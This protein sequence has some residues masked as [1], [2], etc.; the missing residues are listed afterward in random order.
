MFDRGQ[1][2]AECLWLIYFLED[3][4]KTAGGYVHFLLGNH[5]IMNLNND[6][7]YMKDKYRNNSRLLGVDYISLYGENSELGRWLRTKNIMERIGDMLFVHG[8]ISPVINRLPLSIKQLNEI[9]RPHYTDKI[10]FVN[11]YLSML[12]D[13]RT[14]PFWFRGYYEDGDKLKQIPTIQ[15]VDSSLQ[16][17]G[18]NYIVTGHTIVGDTIS[19]WYNKK[20]I[21]IDTKHANGASE[22]LLVDENKYYRVNTTG[23]RILL[24]RNTEYYFSIK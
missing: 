4:A 11:P 6:L 10:D 15:Q 13:T 24:F 20:I 14:S 8:G 22:A 16:K 7:R 9:A 21:N 3:K 18:V 17:F 2:V 23:N 1:Q 5:E 12:F 19:L